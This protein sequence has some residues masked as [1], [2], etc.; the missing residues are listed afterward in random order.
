MPLS[1]K[2]DISQKSCR[3]LIERGEIVLRVKSIHGLVKAWEN[4]RVKCPQFAFPS[5]AK[6]RWDDP[7]A[8]MTVS[9]VPD[10]CSYYSLNLGKMIRA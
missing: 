8:N 7:R 3:N 6:P 9:S 4:D 5:Q 2:T 1:T 10:L